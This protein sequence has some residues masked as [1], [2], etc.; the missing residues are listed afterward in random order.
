MLKHSR[1]RTSSGRSRQMTSKPTLVDGLDSRSRN[2][3]SQQIFE[4]YISLARE[5]VTTGDRVMAESYFQHAEHYLRLTNARLNEQNMIVA[6]NQ[7]EVTE[8]EGVEEDCLSEGIFGGEDD[9]II[10]ELHP[11]EDFLEQ[12]EFSKAS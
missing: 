9:E 3:N 7:P 11:Q 4:K 6:K 5:S 10:S 2:G 12:K 1:T 8:P